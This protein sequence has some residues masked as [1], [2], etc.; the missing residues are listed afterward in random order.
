MTQLAYV[1]EVITSAVV[2]NTK[3]SIA[4]R[5]T[6]VYETLVD[7]TVVR[8]VGEK[9]K[10]RLFGRFLFKI[11]RPDEIEFVSIQ[12]YYEP[13]L[14]VSGNYQLDY[15]RKS[16][17]PVKV[18]VQVREVVLLNH[19]FVPNQ[20]SNLGTDG[21]GIRLEGEERIV[22]E[23]RAFLVLTKYGQDSKPEELP[24]APSA[25]NPEELIDSFRLE[26]IAPNIEVDVIRNRI[27]Q[28]PNDVSR[29]VTEVF[30]ID[31]R[32]VIYAPRYKLTYKCPR[33]GKEDHLLFDGVTSKLLKQ[34]QNMIEV[35]LTVVISGL[36]LLFNT[37]KNWLKP[38]RKIRP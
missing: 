38:I 25:K 16:A 33:I 30:E 36:K 19:T 21:Y 9:A 28:R 3:E 34:N 7:P 11:N 5:K 10:N 1:Q 32:S 24:S 15:Y 8:I 20:N 35:M 12:K 18:D 37:M 22:K 14:V 6:V 27:A 4:E 23:A 26:K 31:S 2:S 29:V 17:Y 13:Y